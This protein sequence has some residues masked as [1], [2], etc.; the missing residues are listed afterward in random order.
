[1]RAL[2]EGPF[3]HA[4]HMRKELMR[5]LSISIRINASNKPMHHELIGM[6]SV[7]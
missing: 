3:K 7:P 6:L 4:E 2:S 1:M 5:E